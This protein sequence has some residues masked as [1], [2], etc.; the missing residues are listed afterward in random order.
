[1]ALG[2][3]HEPA[4]L[5]LLAAAAILPAAVAEG[6]GSRP[7][8]LSADGHFGLV[9]AGGLVAAA[10]S[11]GLT[12]AGARRGDGRTV[13][14]GCAFSTMTALLA[15]HGLTTPG[16][17]VG[18]NGVV[19]LAGAASLPTGAAV[20]AL[21]AL[22]ALRRPDRIGPLLALQALLAA[23]V[24]ALG[25]LGVAHPQLVPMVPATGSTAAIALL[26]IGLAFYTILGHRALRTFGLTRRRSDLGVAIGCV[27]LAVALVSQLMIAPGTLGFYVGHVLELAGVAL[28]G[29]P[30]ALDLLRGGASRPLVG[31][32]S[33][34]EIVAA[35]EA[36]L[37][38]RV[39]TLM[40]RLAEKDCST[41]QHTRRVALLAVR[42]GEQLRLSP[43]TLRHLAVGGLLHDIGK[44]SVPA[45]ILRKP[46]ALNDHEYAAI[47]RHPSNGV[48]LLRE[49]GG[50]PDAVHA[51]V[52]EHHERLDG[53]GYPSGLTAAQ[54]EIGPRVLAVCDVFDAL[55]SDRVYREAWTT[56][57]ALAFMRGEA[58]T[59]FDSR[60]L[61]ALAHLVSTEAPQ[62]IEPVA[63]TA[64]SPRVPVLTPGS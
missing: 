6:F 39:R 50:F 33:A 40:L 7:V 41:E 57:R 49:L 30:V 64:G 45:A 18:L 8:A 47:K 62:A 3:R 21:S 31:D 44:L 20:L 14:L 61:E 35:E 1:M 27:W 59:G 28:V 53:R 37:G 43:A 46:G 22:P 5:A 23:G 26:A 32:L 15:V 60:C 13:L 4:P 12:V 36:Y 38:P 9:L 42:V 24:L 63:T 51:L 2:V 56:E 48:R 25:W 34:A 11:I 52:G 58:G 10:A 54:I 17:L 16:V 29:I 55:V 19:A